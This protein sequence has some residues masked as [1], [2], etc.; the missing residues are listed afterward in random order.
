MIRLV[1]K[2]NI[3]AI[4]HFI[5]QKNIYVL[6]ADGAIVSIGVS[7]LINILRAKY[8]AY[9]DYIDLAFCRCGTT[10]YIRNQ[11]IL[12]KEW[13]KSS[14]EIVLELKQEDLVQKLLLKDINNEVIDMEVYS[15]K[16]ILS[17]LDGLYSMNIDNRGQ[18]YKLTK[19][20]DG[21]VY[22]TSSD[23][24]NTILSLGNDGW[25]H[26][27]SLNDSFVSD[28]L[29]NEAPSFR[30]T[31][32]HAGGLINYDA[33]SKFQ[34]VGNKLLQERSGLKETGIA[35]IG[36]NVQDGMSVFHD[37]A[38]SD[39]VFN[40]KKKIYFLTASGCLSS[41][42]M[43]IRKSKLSKLT[44]AEIAMNRIMGN[45]P[46]SGGVICGRYPV[47][48]LWDYV[49]LVT[50]NDIIEIESEPIISMHTYDDRKLENIVSITC[51]DSINIHAIIDLS[52]FYFG[53]IFR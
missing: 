1:I 51:E 7:D 34:F 23:Y 16:M 9:S 47:I 4:D 3:A 44:A 46:V 17:C 2:L 11:H 24:G 32:A 19:R 36:F 12:I 52:D 20:F 27:S 33:D 31:W 53:S 40:N 43:R 5:Y 41:A 25:T 26:V 18:E 21:K 28:R 48:E 22:G 13:D 15:D 45:R 50:E 39:F 6:L 14:N 37:F 49:L 10:K 8:P 30:T 35:E 38:Q 29:D 42:A